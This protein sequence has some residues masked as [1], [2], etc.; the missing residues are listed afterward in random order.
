MIQT[1]Q[2]K[3]VKA[4]KTIAKLSSGNMP[5]PVSYSLF[6]LKKVLANHF[7]FQI[8]KERE[9]FAKYIPTQQADGSFTFA[10]KADEQ[11]FF[12]QITEISKLAVEVDCPVVTIPLNSDIALSIE[13]MESMDGFVLFE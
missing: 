5:L 12:N 7:E 13:D 8:E 3:I 10:S 9:L 1:T 11:D 2:G 6:K 4:Y